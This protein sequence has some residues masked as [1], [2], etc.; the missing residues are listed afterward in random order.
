MWVFSDVA[1]GRE[2]KGSAE[3]GREG[4]GCARRA[5]CRVSLFLHLKLSLNSGS[6]LFHIKR[7]RHSRHHLPR[8]PKGWSKISSNHLSKTFPPIKAASMQAL[9]RRRGP[10]D[11]L[12]EPECY[13]WEITR[14]RARAHAH[15]HTCTQ[16]TAVCVLAQ[17]LLTKMSRYQKGNEG[18]TRLKLP[19]LCEGSETSSRR[20]LP[21][22]LLQLL[23]KRLSIFL[24]LFLI[25]WL[26]DHKK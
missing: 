21:V 9:R 17:K 14:T 4:G 24:S 15:R 1:E 7:G 2:G 22:G 26:K 20:R 6:V 5:A 16:D 10:L 19:G 8:A 11:K 25:R 3:K 13:S 18:W 12:T 23:Q